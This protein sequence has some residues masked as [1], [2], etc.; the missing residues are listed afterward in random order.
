MRLTIRRYHGG[1]FDQ[2]HEPVPPDP[3]PAYVDL[4]TR[5]PDGTTARHRYELATTD[6]DSTHYRYVGTLPHAGTAR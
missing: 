3:R 1:P 5:N 4:W 2:S 6:P